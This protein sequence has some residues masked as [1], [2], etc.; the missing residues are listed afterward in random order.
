LKAFLQEN[1]TKE[2]IKQIKNPAY[3]YRVEIVQNGELVMPV[4]LRLTYKDGSKRQ[5]IIPAK[6][7]RFNDKK[8]SKLIPSEK[9]I[10]KIELDPENL[11]ADIDESNN[12]WPRK[13]SKSEFEKLK[14]K[15]KF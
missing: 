3:F 4:V 9:E 5:I 14:E 11:T 15:S 12:V 1:F 10:V 13:K 8:I 7:W 2:E 6:V